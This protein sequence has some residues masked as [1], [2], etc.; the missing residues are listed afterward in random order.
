MPNRQ[1][2]VLYVPWKYTWIPPTLLKKTVMQTQAQK[3]RS[4]A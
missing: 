1:I 3:C 4:L 2:L